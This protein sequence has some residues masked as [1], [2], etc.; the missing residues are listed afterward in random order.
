MK[1]EIGIILILIGTIFIGNKLT[2]TGNFLALKEELSLVRFLISL[3]GL[4]F[5]SIGLGLMMSDSLE[6]KVWSSG[7]GDNKRYFLRTG[8]PDFNRKNEIDSKQLKD[9][10]ERLKIE[11]PGIYELMKDIYVPELERILQKNPNSEEAVREFLR[12]FGKEI[13][14]EER[15]ERL[16]QEE[17]REI[18]EA[19]R[20]Y[21][22]HGV[23]SKNQNRVLRKYSIRVQ[24]ETKGKGGKRGHVKLIFPDGYSLGISGSPSDHR[25]GK[26]LG[27]Q[28]IKILE[29]RDYN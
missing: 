5:F 12:I 25:S 8:V 3:I 26:N 11:D 1:R 7:E 17:K 10:L 2:I 21:P 23:L 24:R 19:F 22:R 4:V 20:E 28:I 15:K 6:L 27:K 14:Q 13:P 16:T 18:T 9:Y 29:R